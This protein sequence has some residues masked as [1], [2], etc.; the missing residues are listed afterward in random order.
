MK[1]TAA[2]IFINS[3]LLFLF[4]NLLSCETKNSSSEQAT[5]DTLMLSMDSA[6]ANPSENEPEVDEYE[7]NYIVSVAE[8][9]NY[10]S[11]HRIAVDAASLLK[12]EFDTFGRY[13][14]P[15]RGIILPDNSEDD[16]WAGQYLLRRSGEPKV[17]LERVSFYT[18]A[19]LSEGDEMRALN[20]S[21][22][23][24]MFVF[25]TMYPEKNSADSLAKVLSKT[26]PATKVI[27]NKI[28]IGCMH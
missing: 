24:K 15:K 12:F 18:D 4:V 1:T 27:P 11:L 13:Y 2:P 25:A 7:L 23:T 10:D 3:L 28:Y 17:S 16:I 22:T 6:A 8:G 9:Y 21:D 26:Y 20:E 14:D 5:V 19:S